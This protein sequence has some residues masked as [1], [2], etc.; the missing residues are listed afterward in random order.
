MGKKMSHILLLK[1]EFYLIAIKQIN[2]PIVYSAM[3]K[4]LIM[5]EINF[6]IRSNMDP[7]KSQ[8]AST[9]L[10]TRKDYFSP[11]KNFMM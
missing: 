9:S 8:R 4:L 6:S 1:N 5:R 2:P 11:I 10:K 7:W 3:K